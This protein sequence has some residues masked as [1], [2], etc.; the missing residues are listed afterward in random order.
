MIL[1][2]F[3]FPTETVIASVLRPP[4]FESR[5]STLSFF[6]T[7]LLCFRAYYI[8][9]AR[10]GLVASSNSLGQVSGEDCLSSVGLTTFYSSRVRS[11]TLMD[12]ITNSLKGGCYE[13]CY[14]VA[15][16]RFSFPPYSC[17][18]SWSVLGYTFHDLK[19]VRCQSLP[20]DPIAPW[21]I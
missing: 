5:P 19:R 21:Y 3:K 6:R 17:S 8:V 10:K 11:A 16:D 2:R 7:C 4:F 14:Y 20:R 9:L 12:Q 13:A 15:W 1:P 18:G